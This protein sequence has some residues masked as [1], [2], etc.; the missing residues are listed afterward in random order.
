MLASY[1]YALD[2]ELDNRT[3]FQTVWC[4]CTCSYLLI[5]T[6]K[7]HLCQNMTSNS[8]L[9]CSKSVPEG[10]SYFEWNPHLAVSAP[11][12]FLSIGSSGCCNCSAWKLARFCR[13]REVMCLPRAMRAPIQEA[14][15]DWYSSLVVGLNDGKQFS[16]V[17]VAWS[18]EMEE[19]LFSVLVSLVCDTFS[20][21]ELFKDTV[22][23]L[24]CNKVSVF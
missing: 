4:F 20:E 22:K 21:D 12:P 9:S 14:T 7:L 3:P 23:L 16:A 6:S 15:T 8:D 5:E 2:I 10:A 11:I 24:S 17:L 18:C 1:N 19:S 13:G